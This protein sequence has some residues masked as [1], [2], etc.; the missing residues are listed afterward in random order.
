MIANMKSDQE[1]LF[2]SAIAKL[3][4]ILD[5]LNS[6]E[7]RSVHNPELLEAKARGVSKIRNVFRSGV[8]IWGSTTIC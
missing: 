4:R 7:L 1:A 3:N 5:L 6:E 8:P 2:G